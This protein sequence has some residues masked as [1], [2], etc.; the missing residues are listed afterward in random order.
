MTQNKISNGDKTLTLL[1]TKVSLVLDVIMKDVANEN[2]NATFKNR[3]PEGSRL[4]IF[5]TDKN[6]N[7]KPSS[8]L[9][10]GDGLALKNMIEIKIT[11]K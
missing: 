5:A 7:E 9:V 10:C 11:V 4:K 3:A 8:F 1:E 6:N 2:K